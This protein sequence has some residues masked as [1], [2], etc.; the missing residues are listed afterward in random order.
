MEITVKQARREDASVLSTI[1]QLTFPLAGPSNSSKTGIAKY[2]AE[3]LSPSAFRKLV[4]SDEVFVA[5][6]QSDNVLVGFIVVKYR[7]SCP[8]KVDL[9]N[10]AELQRLYVLPEYHGTNS[11]KLLVS[12]ALKEC[13]KEG[14]VTVWLSVYSGNSRAKMFYSK[15]GFKKIGT[16]YFKMDNEKHLDIIMVASIA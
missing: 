7:S 2:V 16:T 10:S 12:E 14:I 4:E 15:F 6:A 1:A 5:C 3:N 13:S 8:I 9:K 11:T